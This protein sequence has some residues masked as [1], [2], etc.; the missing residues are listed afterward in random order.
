MPRYNVS[1]S[2]SLD[3][4]VTLLSVEKCE[5]KGQVIRN[6]LA[7]LALVEKEFRKDP[8]RELAI[9]RDSETEGSRTVECIIELPWRNDGD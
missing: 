3:R 1:V 6:A 5:T 2:E 7:L 8:T 9:V 4:Q